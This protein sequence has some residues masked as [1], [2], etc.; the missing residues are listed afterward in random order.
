[1]HVACVTAE[2]K[3]A[4]CA[5][6]LHTRSSSHNTIRLRARFQ[7]ALCLGGTTRA[8]KPT[9]CYNLVTTAYPVQSPDGT[10]PS[11]KTT[12]ISQLGGK[13]KALSPRGHRLREAFLRQSLIICRV[14]GEDIRLK[15]SMV[16]PGSTMHSQ[17]SAVPAWRPPIF[18]LQQQQ[19]QQRRTE[20]VKA[21]R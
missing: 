15:E 12:Y 8:T 3:N 11:T 19:Q 17:I 14:P 16:K 4:L 1:M 20:R 7:R 10:C 21:R 2:Q 9:G 13:Q 6:G 5:L 18:L